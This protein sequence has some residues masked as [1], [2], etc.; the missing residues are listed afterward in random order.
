[1]VLLNDWSAREN[2][3]KIC[4]RNPLQKSFA[5]SISILTYGFYTFRVLAQNK[6]QAHYPSEKGKHSFDIHLEA[7]IQPENA[8]PTVI[9]KSNFKY[10]YRDYE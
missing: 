6:I 1:M 8:E 7:A 4:C 9:S 5:S 3:Q 2:S 10:M